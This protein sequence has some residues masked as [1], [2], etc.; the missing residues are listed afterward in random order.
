MTAVGPDGTPLPD[1]STL[2]A[3]DIVNVS[4]AEFAAGEVVPVVLESTPTAVATLTATPEGTLAYAFTVPSNL[5][6]GSHT[7]TMQGLNSAAVFSFLIDAAPASS[8][9]IRKLSPNHGKVGTKV[10]IRGTGFGALGAVSFGTLDAK[11]L[12]W[13]STKIV[14]RVPAKSVDMVSVKSEVRVP[15]WYRHAERVMVTVTPEGDTASIG[16]RFKVDPAKGD[17]RGN[18][19]SYHNGDYRGGH[20]GDR[21]GDDNG[22]R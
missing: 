1:G 6:S 19:D 17:R 18:H 2:T 8:A 15:V 11:V 9:D 13:T 22:D 12:S 20:D 16:M 10:T 14:V 4:G 21:S 3:G 5:E 7:L